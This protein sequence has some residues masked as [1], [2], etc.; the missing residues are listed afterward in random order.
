[1]Q[2]K[3]YLIHSQKKFLCVC[4]QKTYTEFKNQEKFVVI[5]LLYFLLA[6]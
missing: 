6:F 5:I 2:M 3:S 1:M 4:R